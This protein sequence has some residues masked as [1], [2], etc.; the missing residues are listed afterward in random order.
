MSCY[1]SYR[2]CFQLFTTEYDIS[3]A[4]VIY[5]FYYAELHSLYT[6][7]LFKIL[8]INRCWFF[9]ISCIYWWSY[10]LFFNLLMWYIILSCRYWTIRASRDKL[11]LIMVCESSNVLLNSFCY[12][13]EN[14]MIWEH[15]YHYVHQWLLAYNICVCVCVWSLYGFGITVTQQLFSSILFSLHMS[16]VFWSFFLVVHHWSHI[17][18][19]GKDAWYD[20]NLLIFT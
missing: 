12:F 11:Q 2:K 15:A 5:G 13:V 10:D 7:T 1:R 20:I 8:I 14:F 19:A 17:A 3:C 18:V 16:G 6:Y 9:V 4:S